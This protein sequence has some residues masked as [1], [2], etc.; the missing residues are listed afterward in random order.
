MRARALS[1]D[2][3]RAP[4]AGVPSWREFAV[5]FAGLLLALLA[6]AGAAHFAAPASWRDLGAR[7]LPNRASLAVGVFLNNLLIAATPV[8][9]AW[10]AADHRQ[11]GH[12]LAASLFAGLPVVVLVRSVGLIGLVG[13]LDPRWLVDASRWWSLE[14]A[15]LGISACTGW[16]LLRHPERRAADGPAVVRRATLGI[17][18]SLAA[19][20]LIEVFTA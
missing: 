3:R 12:R 4:R 10:L 14:L 7:Q 2:R 15:A 9:G 8:L 6:V 11:R 13:G 1:F 5:T 16:W 20:A 19:G 18:A 17:V